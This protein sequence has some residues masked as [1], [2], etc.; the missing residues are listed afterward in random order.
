MIGCIILTSPFFFD[1][2][3]WI[4]VPEDWKPN[5]VQGKSYHTNETIGARLYQQVQERLQRKA[6]SG[7]VAD[8]VREWEQDEEHRYGPGQTVFPRIGQ[9]AFRILVTE[10]YQRRCAIT[11]EKTLPVLDAAHIKPFAQDG[12]NRTSNGLLLRQ[13]L[14]T[15]FDK[16]YLTVDENLRIEDS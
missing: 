13:D 2:S 11:G 16:G 9:G 5:I 4:P 1:K 14:H 7:L 6:H 8:R 15:L 3:D 10:A 12:P